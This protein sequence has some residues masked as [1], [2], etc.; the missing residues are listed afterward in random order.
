MRYFQTF[1]ELTRTT[2]TQPTYSHWAVGCWGMP[3]RCPSDSGR[4]RVHSL[5]TWRS[6]WNGILQSIMTGLKCQW[7]V[8]VLGSQPARLGSRLWHTHTHTVRTHQWHL[9]ENITTTNYE[10]KCW[11]ILLTSSLV[12]SV[13]FPVSSAVMKNTNAT[14]WYKTKMQSTATVLMV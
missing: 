10:A 1:P 9:T 12:Y 11:V 2:W 5:A 14:Y 4:R 7:A 13:H 6:L 8:E 3:E